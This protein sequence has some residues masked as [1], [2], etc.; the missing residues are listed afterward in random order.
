MRDV[1]LVL[2]NLKTLKSVHPEVPVFWRCDPLSNGL[3]LP[4]APFRHFSS[5]RSSCKREGSSHHSRWPQPISGRANACKRWH[6]GVSDFPLDDEQQS[7]IILL[8][9][10]QSPQ[11]PIITLARPLPHQ[12][13]QATAVRISIEAKR[14]PI[15]ERKATYHRGWCSDRIR[16]EAHDSGQEHQRAYAS[17]VME[18][19]NR[20]IH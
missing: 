17:T 20:K 8:H 7:N 12:A 11:Y 13:A 18:T 5:T 10:T 6:R 1:W 19:P 15:F 3:P 14:A 4:A 16:C 9:E 2:R